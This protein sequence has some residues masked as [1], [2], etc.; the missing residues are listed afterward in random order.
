MRR[1]LFGCVAALCTASAAHAIVI[2]DTFGTGETTTGD[3]LSIAV[4]ASP[5]FDA[6]TALFNSTSGTFCTGAL[7][8]QTAVLTARHCTDGQ[9]DSDWS[10]LFGS[11]LDT[12]SA[13]GVSSVDSLAADPS[14]SYFTGSD[15]AILNL[16][17]A[18]A[19]IDP[20]PVLAQTPAIESVALVGFGRSGV[21]S[22]GAS[23]D[24]DLNKRF[25][26]NTFEA[27]DFGYDGNSLLYADFDNP[28]GTDNSLGAVGSLTGTN[29]EGMIGSGDSG[30]PMLFLRNGGWAIGGVATGVLAFD[31][32][33]DSDYGDLGVWTGFAS[34]Q[35]QNLVLA[36]GGSLISVPLP[37]PVLGLASGIAGLSLLRASRRRSD[38]TGP[39]ATA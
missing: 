13:V 25:A 27:I 16:A 7:I 5:E 21:G 22:T 1:S 29:F 9:T 15:L 28:D 39:Q 38:D 36:A 8:S 19:G 2:N 6:I 18:V 34:D 30:G 11:S 26:V 24:I 32:A 33:A 31:G 35:A 12:F 10:V 37:M 14:G 4:G 23:V 3:D 17:T 20:L